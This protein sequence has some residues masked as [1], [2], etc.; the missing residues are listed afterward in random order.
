MTLLTERLG[1]VGLAYSDPRLTD[2]A[3]DILALEAL[4]MVP[5]VSSI[6]SLSPYWGVRKPGRVEP[7]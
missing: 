3:Y 5:R 4:F 2:L 6:L 1:I 7:A